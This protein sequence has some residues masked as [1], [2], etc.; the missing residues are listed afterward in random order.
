[1]RENHMVTVV[2]AAQTFDWG[3]TIVNLSKN[4]SDFS[5]AG[6]CTYIRILQKVQYLYTN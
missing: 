5:N 1:M 4:F 3:N 6:L 2:I